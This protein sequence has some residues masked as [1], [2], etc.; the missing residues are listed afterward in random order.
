[1]EAKMNKLVVAVGLLIAAMSTAFAQR[2][3]NTDARYG[4]GLGDRA[5]TSL[6]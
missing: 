4:F 3:A 5:P 1:M 2:H 6:R